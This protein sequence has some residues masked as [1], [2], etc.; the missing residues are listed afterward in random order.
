MSRAKGR[1]EKVVVR[2]YLLCVVLLFMKVQQKCAPGLRSEGRWNA[3]CC[4]TLFRG[5]C[6][7]GRAWTV[8][9][10]GGGGGLCANLSSTN[11]VW[12][13]VW[14]RRVQW[15]N[16][17]HTITRRRINMWSTGQLKLT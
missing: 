5:A 11:V 1:A 15:R 13:C 14:T 3:I 16:K 6:L 4:S 17:D 8:R 7:A 9:R 2:G 12:E 10:G